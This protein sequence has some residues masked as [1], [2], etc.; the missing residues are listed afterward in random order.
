MSLVS[1]SPPLSF[2][3]F[4]SPLY[5]PPPSSS[6]SPLLSPTTT[7]VFLKVGCTALLTTTHLKLARP[8]YK[9][10][11]I[12]QPYLLSGAD[13]TG[14]S[15]D[16]QTKACVATLRPVPVKA[17]VLPEQLGTRLFSGI[18]PQAGNHHSQRTT[19]CACGIQQRTDSSPRS[20]IARRACCWRMPTLHKVAVG[21]DEEP[22]C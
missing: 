5:L 13:T 17:T 2:P 22:L 3:S 7:L 18:S 12:L 10:I 16:Y 19:R 8:H 14:Q 11:S 6:F 21:F 9:N 20:T 1:S 4:P 15:W